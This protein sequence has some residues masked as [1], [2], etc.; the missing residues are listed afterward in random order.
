MS[1]ES[2]KASC[3]WV[4]KFRHRKGIQS[5]MLHGEG[6]EVDKKNPELLQALSGLYKKISKYEP[7]N[8]YNMDETGLVFR[9]LSTVSS[10]LPNENV[11]TIRGKKKTKDRIFLTVCANATGTH[12]IPC[13]IIGKPKRLECIYIENARLNIL[14]NQELGWMWQPVKSGLMKFFIPKSKREQEGQFFCLWT[15]HQDILRH[16]D[17]IM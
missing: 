4:K 9:T 14:I 2:F 5:M 11:N 1:I 3:Q 15:M 6:A 16:L 13:T 17:E 10:A 7:E 12:K 8:V